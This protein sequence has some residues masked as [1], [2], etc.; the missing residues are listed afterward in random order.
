[1]SITSALDRGRRAAVSRMTSTCVIRRQAGAETR[2]AAGFRNTGW[3]TVYTGPCR[4]AGSTTGYSAFHNQ[5][6]GGTEEQIATRI[7]HLPA[8]TAGISDRDYVQM[9][10]GDAS[11]VVLQVIETTPQDQATARRLGVSE[12]TT[13]EGW[14]T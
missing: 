9:T 13:P 8:D 12:V 4:L 10:S 14:P 6:V 1:M 3:T 7:L 11:G 5:L 2:D